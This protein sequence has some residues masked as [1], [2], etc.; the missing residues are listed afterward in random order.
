MVQRKRFWQEYKGLVMFI[1]CML[2]FRSA[3]ADWNYVP[4][5][6]MN[7]TLIAGD[8]VVVNKLAYSLRVPFTLREVKRWAKPVAGD[9][10]TFD[11][12]ADGLN[13]IKRV[14]AVE[15]DTVAMVKNQLV[16]NGVAQPRTL[17]DRA[18]AIATE[19]GDLNLQVW[20]EQLGSFSHETALIPSLNHFTNFEPVT[21][22]L[23]QVMVLGDSRDN[24]RDSRFIGFIDMQRI[25]GRAERVAMSHN[26]EKFYLP[27]AQRWWLPL[28]EG[29]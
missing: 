13:L 1:A 14:V 11:S 2:V 26:P 18:R 28:E 15:G 12:P 3:M 7:P 22:P 6:S 9:V 25:T 20:R 24:S 27:R 4:S 17:I 21:V 5:S 19:R 23:G 8:R 29:I 10:I 16:V